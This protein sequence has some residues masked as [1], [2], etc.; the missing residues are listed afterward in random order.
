MT[1]DNRSRIFNR[2][3]TVMFVVLFMALIGLLA[4]LST[5]YTFQA[6]WTSGARNTLS[7]PSQE[8]LSRME[9]VIQITAY[10]RETDGLRDGITEMIGRYQRYKEN[11]E[12][13]FINPDTMPDQI[14]ELGITQDGELR[15][16]YEGRTEKAQSINEQ[17]ITNA[18][19]RLMRS[20][21]RWIVF[22]EGHGERR[23]HGQ[24][25]HDMSEWASHLERKG[26]KIR[27]IN[28]VNTPGIPDNTNVLVIASPQVD[29]LPG[30]VRI[31]REYINKGGNVLWLNEP[32]KLN[33]LE[34]VAEPLGIE[35]Q[36]GTIVD[37]VSQLFGVKHPAF[38]VVADYGHHDVTM[39]FN[40]ITLFPMACGLEIDAPEGWV[41]T[42]LLESSARS[43]SE[44]GKLE[45]EVEFNKGSDINGPLTMGI[46]L[47]RQKITNGDEEENNTENNT[48]TSSEDNPE[49]NVTN[50]ID[51]RIV[52]ICD[53]D[54][55]SNSYLGNGGNLDLGLNIINWLSN[56][57][58]II[59]IRAK[60]APDI[61]LELTNVSSAVIGFGFLFIL[62]LLLIGSGI[63][64][65]LKR[66]NR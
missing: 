12:L 24:A 3:Q 32:G 6:D 66:R 19:Q 42:P 26:I 11:I 10:A 62:P 59:A 5:R 37:P 54:F 15:I 25:N 18:L 36:P 27:S 46:A 52:V 48:E 1:P 58:E 47:T 51:Q 7:E 45:G 13:S 61:H 63:F 65:W 28:L 14:R 17:T 38:A 40:T 49:N 56:D 23:A 8:L 20:G 9:P 16:K 34:S 35:F 31:I 60:T 44:T 30:E 21:E 41:G 2:I 33:G 55:L 29:L 64:I 53:G 39:D 57:D 43:W 4:W 50:N 22:L